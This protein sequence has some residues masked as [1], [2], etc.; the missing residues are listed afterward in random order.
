MRIDID[1]GDRSYPVVIES[2]ILAK[3]KSL[4]A[5]YIHGKQVCIVTNETISPLYLKQ[6]E[7]SLCSSY[8]VSAVV[9]PDGEKYK[10]LDYLKAI[11]ETLL[12]NAA[13]R[14]VTLIALGGGV[15]GDMTGF[16][17]A[18]FMRGVNFIQIPTTLLA[19][20]D[21]SVGGKTGVNHPLGKNMIGAFHQP[22]CVMIDVSLLKTLPERELSA[23]L[24]EVIKY[25]FILEPDFIAW[26]EDNMPDLLSLKETALIEAIGISCRAKANIVSADETEKG[27]RA[28][29]NLG[30]T[31]GHALESY[32]NYERYLHGEAVAIG[33]HM[34]LQLSEKMHLIDESDLE[35]GRKLL[36]QANLPIMTEELIDTDTLIAFMKVDKKAQSGEIRLILLNH[37]G[38]AFVCDE[39][40]L[41]KMRQSMINCMSNL[42]TS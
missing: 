34:A 22:V 24:A 41:E 38:K 30:H 18:S 5:Q 28:I 14:D 36:L 1:L 3:S 16:A 31:F 12:Y 35:R 6:L 2:N 42:P 25:G 9:L 15:V 26:L 4:L 8:D 29:L 27:Q 10:N 40:P 19:Q 13:N 33:M 37:L 21:S 7:A 17:A 32:Y 11:F 20:V 23:G 39:F